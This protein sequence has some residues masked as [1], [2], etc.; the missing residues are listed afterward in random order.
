MRSKILQMILVIFACLACVSFANGE[1]CGIGTAASCITESVTTEYTYTT[2]YRNDPDRFPESGNIV[3]Q[4]GKNGSRTSRHMV[5]YE[6]GIETGWQELGEEFTAPVNE[7]V[8]VPSKG[9]TVEIKEE[10]SNETILFTT[11]T[12]YDPNRM[13]GEKDQVVQEG[14]NGTKTIVYAVTYTDGIETNRTV[15]RE[16]VTVKPVEKIISVATGEYDVVYETVTVAIPFE[17]I[18]E[19]ASGWCVGEEA[20]G[21]E[22]QDGEKEV[23]YRI[24]KDKNGNVV[25]RTVSDEKITKKAVNKIIYRGTFV[26]VVTYE[27]VYV[28]DLPECDAS[29]RTTDLNNDCT[30]W[31][32][33]M[34]QENKVQHSNLGFG[35][36]VGGWG[37]IDEVVYGRDYSVISTQNGQLYNGIVSLGSH[38]GQ[39]LAEGK[40]WGAGCVARTETQPDGSTQTV[41]Y[42]CARSEY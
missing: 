25:S 17:T 34:A 19:D 37:S 12:D 35:E 26:P 15:K 9:H 40:T 30:E 7:I 33:K 11:R 4:E 16:S 1:A 2:E 10:T 42:A 41:Y 36:S 32:M 3:I 22:G 24:Q 27:V 14:K 20:V 8:S 28:P 18:Y 38:G 13:K 23:T 29:R 21:N 31:A 39:C 5:T 6:D